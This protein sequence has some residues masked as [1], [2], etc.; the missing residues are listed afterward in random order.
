MDNEGNIVGR[1]CL[2]RK[3]CNDEFYKI[4][5]IDA[6]IDNEEVFAP[7]RGRE[8]KGEMCT[9]LFNK[10]HDEQGI[11]ELFLAVRPNNK[12]ALRAN[13]KLGAEIIGKKI[14]LRVAGINIPYYSL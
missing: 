4:R 1:E 8:Y 13:E 2:L 14:F 9:I 6:Y 5:N 10:I 3:G 7:Y 11:D 12:A